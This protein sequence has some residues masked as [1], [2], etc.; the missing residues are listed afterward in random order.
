[1][2]F[3]RT[4]VYICLGLIFFCLAFNFVVGLDIFDFTG[5]SGIDTSS[6]SSAIGEYT[7]MDNEGYIWTLVITGAAAAAAGVLVGW[8]THAGLTPVAVFLFSDVFWVS[9]IRTH[10]IFS[11]GSYIPQGFLLIFFVGVTFMFIAAII[12]LVTGVN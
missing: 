12:N 1:M 9:Y 2:S 5:A 7:N 10:T 6:E 4:S 8:L 11:T 3:F